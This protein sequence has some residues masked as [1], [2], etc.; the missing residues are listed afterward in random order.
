MKRL[1]DNMIDKKERRLKADA[2]LVSGTSI[3]SV[4]AQLTIPEITVRS[5]KK[6]LEIWI[7]VK[8]IVIMNVL[9]F[10]V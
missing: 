10:S 6:K 2:L 5:W 7:I 9:V 1:G 3:Q 8:A 4:A